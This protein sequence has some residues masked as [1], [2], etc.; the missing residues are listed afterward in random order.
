M[1]GLSERGLS[2]RAVVGGA[3]GPRAH[4]DALAVRLGTSP[5]TIKYIWSPRVPAFPSGPAAS[6]PLAEEGG[7]LHLRRLRKGGGTAGQRRWLPL[8]LRA[9]HR[10]EAAGL[11]L[12]ATPAH[13][14]GEPLGQG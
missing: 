10:G 13:G 5:F 12:R 1:T 6:L 9:L 14:S 7:A 4:A 2:G 8:A 11:L 3:A